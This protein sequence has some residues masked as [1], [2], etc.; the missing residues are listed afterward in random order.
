MYQILYIVP[1]TVG[2]IGLSY[3]YKRLKL[4]HRLSGDVPDDIIA[5]YSDL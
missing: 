5:K 1:I 4:S 3:M 2:I